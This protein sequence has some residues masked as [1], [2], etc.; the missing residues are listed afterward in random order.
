MLDII[1]VALDGYIKD[2]G[3]TFNLYNNA[4]AMN[5]AGLALGCIFFNPFVHKY[6]R[7]PFYL[8]SS[9]IQLA[10]AIWSAALNTP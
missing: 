1:G 6:G 7:R 5:Y 4:C 2:I 9:V 10:A 8:I 3:L